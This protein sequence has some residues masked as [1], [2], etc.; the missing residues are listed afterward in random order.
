MKKTLQTL[1]LGACALLISGCATG[2]LGMKGASLEHF[3]SANQ[4]SRAQFLIIHYTVTDWPASVRALTQAGRGVSAHYLVRDEPAAVYQ[5]VDEN[6]RAWQA[7]VSSW[8][9]NTNL[10]SSSIGIEI[11]NQGFTESSDVPPVRTYYPFPQAQI[12][13]V[14]RLSKDIVARHHIKPEHVLGHQDIAPGRKS[15]PGPLF[16]WKQFYAAGLIAWPDAAQVAAKQAEY[17]QSG[18][19]PDIAWAQDKLG[20][21]GYEV[22]HNG[23]FDEKTKSVILTFQL[24]YRPSNFD[25]TLDAETAAL[26]DVATTKGGMVMAPQPDP[27]TPK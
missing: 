4:D 12:D 8:A 2:P 23:V 22:S 13:E 11:V 24:K 26:I 18:V 9:G 16:P 25:G 15:D 3:P 17:E 19:L 5:L 21:F 20:R 10:N 1:L 27:T 6:R 7:G 14:I